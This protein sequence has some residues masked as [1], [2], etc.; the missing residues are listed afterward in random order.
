ML[1][2][3]WLKTPPNVVFPATSCSREGLPKEAGDPVLLFDFI[4]G[5]G[6][7][8]KKKRNPR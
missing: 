8:K 5:G 3:A 4:L 1:G 2:S 7:T 6:K